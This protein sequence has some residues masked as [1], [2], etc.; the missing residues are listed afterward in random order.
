MKLAALQPSARFATLATMPEA[1]SSASKT[2]GS[3]L[4][5]EAQ[6]WAAYHSFRQDLHPDVMVELEVPLDLNGIIKV[7]DPVIMGNDDDGDY[8][9]ARLTSGG[10]SGPVFPGSCITLRRKI[11]THAQ[12]EHL[13]GRPVRSRKYVKVSVFADETPPLRAQLDIAPVL[14]GWTPLEGATP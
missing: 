3:A 4:D 12:I 14:A 5:C 7:E 6:L 9:L 1:K 8:F 11:H 10:M 2:D 13:D